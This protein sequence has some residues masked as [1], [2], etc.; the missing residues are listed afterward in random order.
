MARFINETSAALRSFE[1]GWE[2]G[3]GAEFDWPGYDP[4]KHGATP[5][6]SR[7][8]APPAADADPPVKARRKVPADGEPSGDNS[9]AGSGTGNDGGGDQPGANDDAAKAAGEEPT[10]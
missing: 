9:E 5:G 4:E 7:L 1:H 3:T 8:D 6:L 10:P 2:V